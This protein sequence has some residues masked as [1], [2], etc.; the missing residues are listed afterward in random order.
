VRQTNVCQNPLCRLHSGGVRSSVFFRKALQM[1]SRNSIN[2]SLNLENT[3]EQMHDGLAAIAPDY[4]IDNEMIE[5]IIQFINLHVNTIAAD[6]TQRIR[7]ECSQRSDLLL[8]AQGN[9]GVYFTC[10]WQ[11]AIHKTKPTPGSGKKDGDSYLD[12]VVA[13]RPDAAMRGWLMKIN[14][15]KPDA[16]D[17]VSRDEKV[18]KFPKEVV[19]YLSRGIIT[20]YQAICLGVQSAAQLGL[21]PQFTGIIENPG[22]E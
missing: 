17:K 16:V 7:T 21:Q 19:M 15:I 11:Q 12:M 20:A 13:I 1:F 2:A 18:E 3:D 8:A 10:T 22:T 4:E 9:A 6:P 14:Y 5:Y